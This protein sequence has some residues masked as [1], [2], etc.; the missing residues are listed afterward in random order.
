MTME[1]F[2]QAEHCQKQSQGRP[3]S[4]VG[5]HHTN[6]IAERLIKELQSMTRA[7]LIFA[8]HRWKE[9]ITANLWPDAMRNAKESINASSFCWE[10]VTRPDFSQGHWYPQTQNTSSH[11]C[12]RY[13]SSTLLSKRDSHTQVEGASQ[14]WYKPWTLPTPPKECGA[15]IESD[16]G[17]RKP[18]VSRPIR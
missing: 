15:R 3:F 2:V 5:A 4:A 9:A 6:G 13:M 12:V 1:F 11:L 18:T 17:A 7:S 16:D 14:S 8:N 10:E